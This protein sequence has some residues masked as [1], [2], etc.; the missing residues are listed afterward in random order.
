MSLLWSTTSTREPKAASA[1]KKLMRLIFDV[2]AVGRI[3]S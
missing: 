1:G 3:A 2:S